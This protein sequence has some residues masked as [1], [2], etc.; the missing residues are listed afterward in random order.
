MRAETY[1]ETVIRHNM[2]ELVDLLIADGSTKNV[3]LLRNRAMDDQ[4]PR[5]CRING[6][7]KSSSAPS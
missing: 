2:R 3:T 6:R 4:L 5:Y 1:R 7:E